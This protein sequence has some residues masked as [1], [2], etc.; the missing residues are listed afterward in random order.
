VA[1]WEYSIDF[2][3]RV[4]PSLLRYIKNPLVKRIVN[5]LIHQAL[6]AMRAWVRTIK[7]E[8]EKVERD[9]PKVNIRGL[10]GLA[11][12]LTHAMASRLSSRREQRPRRPA[13]APTAR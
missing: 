8:P 2:S 6:D 9:Y 13:V 11:T 3:E 10:R 5:A 1:G 12:V 7:E 4:Y